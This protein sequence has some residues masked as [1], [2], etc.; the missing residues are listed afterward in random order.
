MASDQRPRKSPPHARFGA[1]D[2]PAGA[3]E[4]PRYE[5]APLALSRTTKRKASGLEEDESGIISRK[6]RQ[7]KTHCVRDE[8]E[9]I[10]G[11]APGSSMSSSASTAAGSD[12]QA[13]VVRQSA[14]RYAHGHS[15][16]TPE[17]SLA[18]QHEVP[19]SSP[20]FLSPP[21]SS[22]TAIPP[23]TPE[24]FISFEDMIIWDS[25]ADVSSEPDYQYSET[26]SIF[27]YATASS[28]S[29]SPYFPDNIAYIEKNYCF[30]YEGL[31]LLPSEEDP[32]L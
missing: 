31:Q 30:D 4:E 27:S 28:L 24:D 13:V 16:Q 19:S 14:A 22:C 11:S 3:A 32:D 2:R 7:T 12:G 9:L 10:P 8:L 15:S 6:K 18:S 1:A 23:K 5:H 20:A 29:E 25:E 17:T 21:N 26:E